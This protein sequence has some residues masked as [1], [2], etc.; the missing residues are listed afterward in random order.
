MKI[1]NIL[2]VPLVSGVFLSGVVT[3]LAFAAEPSILSPEGYH[4]EFDSPESLDGW[5]VLN[6]NDYRNPKMVFTPDAVSVEDGKLIITTARHCVDSL[7]DALTD[8]NVSE[9][10]CGEKMTR[11]TTAR[12]ES[13][14]FEGGDFSVEVKAEIFEPAQKG[15]RSAIWLQ[16]DQP[17][18]TGD[19]TTPYYGEIDMLEHYSYPGSYERAP[20]T[21][22]LGCNV[23]KKKRIGRDSRQLWLPRQGVEQ[24]AP[25]PTSGYP[26]VWNT[27]YTWK[28]YVNDEDLTFTI[29]GFDVDEDPETGEIG[30][31]INHKSTSMSQ[32]LWSGI[33]ARPWRLILNQRVED[34]D[35]AVPAADTDPFA[36]RRFEIDF[37]NIEYPQPESTTP[38]TPTV[39]T[40]T[41]TVP[42]TTTT[43]VT[44]AVPTTVTEASPTTVT[45]VEPTPTTVTETSSTT[46][47]E[48]SSTTVTSATPTTVTEISPTTVTVPSPTTVTETSSTTTTETSSTTVTSATPTTVTEISPTTVTV[49]SPTTVTT[50][51]P[52]PVTT[53]VTETASSTM[54]A[55][56]TETTPTTVTVTDSVPITVTAPV[57]TPGTVT[58]VVPMTVTE[59]APTTVTESDVVTVTTTKVAP[60]ETGTETVTTTAPGTTETT[61]EKPAANLSSGLGAGN[62][63]G[64]VL[65][66]IFSVI[67]LVS[68]PILGWLYHIGNIQRFIKF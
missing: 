57:I 14:W 41:E 65:L 7:D 68:I 9:E 66:R 36:V 33:M 63:F 1:R 18:C 34:Q 10:P 59:I 17:Y 24:D 38:A 6:R 43:T 15:V 29:D 25:L 4:E 52:T 60:G 31:H 22:H 35:W 56:I 55:T 45:V 48:T 8:D 61:T 46:T 2:A 26:S 13:P 42:V 16:N 19:D 5:R 32:G 47:T 67:S 64:G 50:A 27:P 40:V 23:A 58:T 53:T 37:V 3:P 39:T 21:V 20:I 11:Y 44:T 12:V 51:T 30:K 49:P 54:T 62:R 28:V